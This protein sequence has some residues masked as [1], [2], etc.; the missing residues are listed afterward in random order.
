MTGVCCDS[1]LT[2]AAERIPPQQR[3][4]FGQVPSLQDRLRAWH[5]GRELAGRSEVAL[6]KSGRS[7]RLHGIPTLHAARDRWATGLGRR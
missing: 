3:V 5:A 4:R 2:I 6:I 1:S 7:G